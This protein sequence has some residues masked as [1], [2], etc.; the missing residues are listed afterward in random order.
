MSTDRFSGVQR[1][2]R[3]LMLPI[4]VLPIAGLLLRIGQPDLLN[5]AFIAAAGDAVFSNLGVLFAVGIA[6]GFARENHGAAGLAGAVGYFVAVKGAVVLSGVAPDMVAKMSSRI[7]IPVGILIGIIAGQLYNRY[8]DIKLPDYL[9]FFGG[10]RFVPIVTG[11]AALGIAVLF[12]YGWPAVDAGLSAL[13]TGVLG[14]GKLGLFLYGVL[15]R[16]LIITGLHHIINN[17]AWFLLGDYQG[18]TG[19]LNRF[20]KGDPTA[21]AFMAG[22]FPVMMFGLPA[23]C[24]AMYHTAKPQ[25]RAAVGGVLLSMALTAF[26]TGVTEPVEFAFMFLAPV[27]FAVH[28]LLT[29]LSMV[30]MDA[31]NVKLG[32][33]FSAGLFDYV[34]NYGKATNPILLLP[35]G[36]VYFAVYY[37]LFRFAIRR[38]DLKTLGRDDMTLPA[39]QAEPAAA[40]LRPAMAAA[41]SVSPADSRA[42]AYVAALGGAGNLRSVEACTTRLRLSV[43][44]AGRVDEAELKRLGAR[45]VVKPSANSVQVIVGPV[46]DQLSGEIQEVLRT[47]AGIQA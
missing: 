39:G 14:L 43:A 41:P 31:L 9:A 17:I 7:S 16:V 33:G 27:L 30:L 46:A 29:G 38:F 15:N 35:V 45:G 23:A 44:D 5:I 19:D 18:V 34:L 32:F 2:G 25:N 6:I 47:P 8:K 37:G 42:A 3:A 21:G 1:L 22:F 4:A 11:L 20:F 10:R 12:G 36:A 40:G 13:T 26:L 28:A 24:L